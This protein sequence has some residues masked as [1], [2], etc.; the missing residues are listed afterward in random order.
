[1]LCPS[2]GSPTETSTVSSSDPNRLWSSMACRPWRRPWWPGLQTLLDDLKTFFVSDLTQRGKTEME[3]NISAYVTSE[4][5]N[6]IF[7]SYKSNALL[8]SDLVFFFSHSPACFVI[9]GS[10]WPPMLAIVRKSLLC[11]WTLQSFFDSSLF[12]QVSM[13]MMCTLTFSIL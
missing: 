13:Y 7:L 10:Q 12:V 5:R 4:R 11:N 9:T 2:R 3:Y 1:M 6:N 8:L